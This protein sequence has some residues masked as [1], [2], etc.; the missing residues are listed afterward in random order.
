MPSNKRKFGDL[1]EDIAIKFL[2]KR[3][4]QYIE[5]NYRKKYGEIDLIFTLGKK[6]VFIEVKT[7]EKSS[8][9]SFLPEFNVNFAKTKKL[10]HICKVY[11]AEHNL[12]PEAGWSIDVI[13]MTIDKTTKSATVFNIENW[14]IFEI[15]FPNNPFS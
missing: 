2:I 11:L 6:Y 13:A 9:D 7:R 8:S 5:R 14:Q 1:G 3:G 4:Y 10:R 15:N 12:F